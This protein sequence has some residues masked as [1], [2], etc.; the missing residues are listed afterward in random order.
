MDPLLKLYQLGQAK[1]A[2]TH[3][4]GAWVYRNCCYIRDQGL[5][6]DYVKPSQR[7]LIYTTE[8]YDEALDNKTA[9][10]SGLLKSTNFPH[11]PDNSDAQ[12]GEI[13]RIFFAQVGGSAGS[14]RGS[15]GGIL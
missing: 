5:N 12:L 10:G 13:W 2:S 11:I 1:T 7:A 6:T 15:F 9:K 3:E 8:R 14:L 4:R